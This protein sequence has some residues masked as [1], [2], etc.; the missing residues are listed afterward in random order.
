MKIQL[1]AHKRIQGFTLVE[2]VIFIML[3]SIIFT[4]LSYTMA[5]TLRDAKVNE[6]KIIASR[7]AQELNEWL[8]SEKE[9]DW[10]IFY[11]TRASGAGT[12][13]CFNNLTLNSSS[14]ASATCPSSN[15]DTLY[16]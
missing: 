13:Y 5:S 8:G 1:R 9:T 10:S 2:V 6:H 15:L 12:K 3:I 14:W 7:Y 16:Q 4:V 11:N